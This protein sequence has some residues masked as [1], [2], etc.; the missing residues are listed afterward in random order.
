[1][2]ETKEQK[3]EEAPKCQLTVTAVSK[4]KVRTNVKAGPKC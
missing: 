2:V 4:L 3:Q 1:M